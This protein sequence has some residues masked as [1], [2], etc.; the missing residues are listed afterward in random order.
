MARRRF[1]ARSVA[2]LAVVALAL[3]AFDAAAVGWE[4][5]RKP[6]VFKPD[7]DVVT[8]RVG[9]WL[10]ASYE[11][12]D[13][14]TSTSS[15]NANH[16]NVFFDTRY[17]DTW[18]FFFEAEFEYETDL[19]G[20]EEEREYEV[21]QA[22][23]RYRWAD[24]LEAR[25]GVFNIPFGFWTPIHWTILMDTIRPPMHESQRLTPEQQYGFGLSGRWFPGELLGREAELSYAAHVGYGNDS[26]FLKES[27][28]DGWSAGADLRLSFQEDQF[29]GVSYY[30]RQHELSRDR[31][32]RSFV[33]Y[34]QATLPGNLLARGEYV[35][36]L[37]DQNARP[38]F[39]RHMNVAYAK[40]RWRFHPKAYLN[41]RF[42]WGDDDS[43]GTTLQRNV[44]TWTLGFQPRPWLRL[45]LEYADHDF[46]DSGRED[47]R[48]W[49]VSVGSLF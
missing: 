40:L 23:V 31:T 37:R 29:L 15:V 2:C 26:D 34:G 16:V 20:F 36:Q 9:G 12:N 6:E 44:H 45:K 13:L 43:A 46:R 17:R 47:F 25:V 22:Y 3:L 14:D 38:S 33:L 49:G 7:E 35:R 10:D 42:N 30:Q 24:A 41:Y 4:L 48:Y 21:E 39:S 1:G 27:E 19:V 8:T 32:E 18:Q 5:G 28:S 11:D